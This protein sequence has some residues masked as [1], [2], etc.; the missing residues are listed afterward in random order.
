VWRDNAGQVCAYTYP[1]EGQ[2]CM[3]WP[4]VARFC[5]DSSGQIVRAW[6][7]PGQPRTSVERVH[8]RAVVP[9]ALQHLG[10]ETLH[11]SAASFP[12]GVVGFAG[13]AG[14]GKSTIA[15]ACASAGADHWADDTLVVRI[16][17][18]GVQAVA[19]PFD[20]ALRDSSK[21]HFGSAID[22]G[23]VSARGERALTGLLLL[24]RGADDMDLARVPP[25]DAL[26]QLLPHACT[27][28]MQDAARRR[29]LAEQY[30]ALVTEVP[31]YRLSYPTDY[32][33]LAAVVELIERQVA[34]TDGG[35]LR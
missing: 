33:R 32:T 20:V 10:F 27:F 24:D 23:V 21:Q 13:A 22:A 25:G 17:G 34:G 9:A 16:A 8:R 30:L 2:F 4:G 15:R 11:A 26:Q 1:V 14:A 5:F 3:D 7:S 19:I 12:N 18:G 31:V 29:R 35:S 28:T 6:P